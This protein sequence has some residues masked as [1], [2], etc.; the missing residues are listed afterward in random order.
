MVNNH[1]TITSSSGVNLALVMFVEPRINA[2]TEAGGASHA[3]RDRH[4][5]APTKET[6]CKPQGAHFRTSGTDLKPTIR[7]YVLRSER[8]SEAADREREAE[9]KLPSLEAQ[10]STSKGEVICV[11]R[12]PLPVEVMRRS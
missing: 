7:S 2:A 9:A 6:T 3:P 1:T 8:N 12:I 11:L 4:V 10:I 5:P